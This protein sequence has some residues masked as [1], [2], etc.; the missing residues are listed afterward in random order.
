[1][2]VKLAAPDT[3]AQSP[4]AGV[5]MGSVLYTVVPKQDGR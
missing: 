4:T 3:D 5:N 2:L 1:M